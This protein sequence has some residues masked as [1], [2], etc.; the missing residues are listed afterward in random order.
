MKTHSTPL[1]KITIDA[2][3]C[4]GNGVRGDSFYAVLFRLKGKRFLANVF[5]GDDESTHSNKGQIAVIC[6]DAI[7]DHGVT[8][9]VNSWRGEDDFGPAIRQAIADDIA[10]Y[11][12]G[13]ESMIW[14]RRVTA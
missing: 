4:H 14:G 11:D 7:K 13:R 8:R 2:M 3:Q 10:E 9:G 6:L 5:Q 1:G 12:A